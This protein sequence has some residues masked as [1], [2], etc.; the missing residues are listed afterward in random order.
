[1]R[2]KGWDSG[3]LSKAWHHEK[4]QKPNLETMIDVD[5]WDPRKLGPRFLHGGYDAALFSRT[6]IFNASRI[7][8]HGERLGNHMIRAP[9][10][11]EAS[12]NNQE[13]AP[14]AAKRHVDDPSD[15]SATRAERNGLIVS[16]TGKRSFDRSRMSIWKKIVKDDGQKENASKECRSSLRCLMT[17]RFTN[18]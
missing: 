17:D 8:A 16:L 11:A 9:L 1:M 13:G 18:L 6:S 7:P 5:A 15:S 3:H 12:W 14:K 2:E 10:D 4:E